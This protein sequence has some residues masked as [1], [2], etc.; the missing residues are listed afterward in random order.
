MRTTDG[1]TVRDLVEEIELF[2]G[3]GVDLRKS[4]TWISKADRESR[5]CAWSKEEE[6][7][8][9]VENIEA[10]HVDSNEAPKSER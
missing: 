10:G 9:L 4:I 8:D 7:T 1:D 6:Q 5:G 2:D 3:D